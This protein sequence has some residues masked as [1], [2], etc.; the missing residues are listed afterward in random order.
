MS[1]KLTGLPIPALFLLL[2]AGL[3][4]YL[5]GMYGLSWH[6]SL[7]WLIGIFLCFYVPGNILLQFF[8]P[9]NCTCI[10]RFFLSLG[11]GSAFVPLIYLFLR[12]WSLAGL[13]LPLFLFLLA[14]WF[15]LLVKDV[16]ERKPFNLSITVQEFGTVTA[17]V[18]ILLLLLHL[19][20]FTDIRFTPEGYGIRTT[21]LT[22]T[23]FHLGL[24]NAL[25]LSLIHISE[26]TRPY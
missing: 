3:I 17:A 4:F 20:H 5:A 24:V 14:F 12:R 8:G 15:F 9:Q 2:L 7:F 16:R 11:L 26:P 6:D 23:V 1:R 22:E 25:K 13:T 19:S 10:I 18:I 21:N